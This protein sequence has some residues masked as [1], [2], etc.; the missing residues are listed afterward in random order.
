MEQQNSNSS[1]LSEIEE[2]RIQLEEAHDT[3]NAIRTGQVDALVVKDESGHQLFTL[4]TADQTYRVFIEKMSEGAVTINHNGIILYCNTRF[5]SMAATS[6]EKTIGQPLESFVPEASKA[7]LEQI[8]HSSWKE[9]CRDELLLK[10]GAGKDMHCLFSCNAIELDHGPALSIII[11]DLTVLKDTERQLQVRNTELVA[12]HAATEKLNDSLEATVRERTHDLVISREHFRLL[13]NNIDQMTWTNLP[14]GEFI[15]YNQRWFDYTG[16]TLD[17][18][19]EVKWEMLVH[20][21]DLADTLNQYNHSLQTGDLFEVE[22]RYKRHD[23]V[24]R[25]HLNR[26]KPLKNDAGD[27]I[28][29][30]GTATDIEEQKKEMER[31]DEFIGIASH[32]LKTPL[33]SLKG[34]VQLIAAYKKEELPP[35]VKQYITKATVSINK[36]Q[37]LI[38]D[39]L[40]VSKI[41]AGRLQYAI[42]EVDIANL[43]NICVENAYHAHPNFKFNVELQPGFTVSGNQERLE[44]VLMN[45]I[46]NAVKYSPTNREVNIAAV[47]QSDKVRVAVTDFGIG[48]SADQKSKIFERFYRVEDKQNMTSG[49]GMGLYISQEIVKNHNGAIGVESEPGKGSTFYFVLPLV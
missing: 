34:Y 26:S 27:I 1:L 2:L 22:N 19:H 46:N 36:L 30:V 20:P 8:I 11:T 42:G 7:K 41:K 15:S 12:A 5:A 38:N 21:D 40:D 49:L 39:L 16:L 28:F 14:T 9:E 4:K 48:L 24:Y 45:L 35:V 18:D 25:W 44:Q 3:I 29:W 17:D 10:D 13:T 33:T 47:Q 43:V 6:L 23:G 31:K 37:S 32:E